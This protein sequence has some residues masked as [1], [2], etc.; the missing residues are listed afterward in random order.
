[1]KAI[2]IVNR[3]AS[4]FLVLLLILFVL[5]LGNYIVRYVSYQNYRIMILEYK[6]KSL[7]E[8]KVKQDEMNI[9]NSSRLFQLLNKICKI[10]HT[11]KNC[12]FEK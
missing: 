6:V 3:I 9:N 7:N 1:M 8:I 2:K 10:Q 4:V 12:V 5:M 11:E